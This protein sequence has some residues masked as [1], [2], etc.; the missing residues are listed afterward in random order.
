[1]QAVNDFTTDPGK[2]LGLHYVDVPLSPATTEKSKTLTNLSGGTTIA[3]YLQGPGGAVLTN[4]SEPALPLARYDVSFP[5]LVL[6][7]VG[8]REGTF[9]TPEPTGITPLTGAATTEQQAVHGPF[10]PSVFF[11][12]RLWSVNYFG[13]L[14]GLGGTT[15]NVTP[16]QYK[17][18]A[19]GSATDTLRRYSQFV[20]RLY[21][22]GETGP[23]GPNTPALAAPPAIAEID[24]SVE[25]AAVKFRVR[26]VGDPSAGIQQ[27]WVSYT[28]V[29]AG[30]WESLD[31]TQDGTDSTLWTGTLTLPSGVQAS[32]VRY[33]AQAVNGVGLTSLDDN[34]GAYYAPAGAGQAEP[35][36]ATLKLVSPPATGVYRSSVN[37]TAELTDT[38]TGAPLSGKVV[39]LAV[40]T[41]TRTA[42]TDSNGRASA[43]V[44]LTDLPGDYRLTVAFGGD[45]G[46]TGASASQDGVAITR[47][48][49]SLTID[50]KNLSA[51]LTA[52]GAPLPE[53]TVLLVLTRADGSVAARIAR[54]TDRE[55]RVALGT[56]GLG[57]DYTLTAYFGGTISLPTGPITLGDPT[58]YTTATAHAAVRITFSVSATGT[59]GGIVPPTLS[60]VLGTPASFGTFAPGVDRNYDASTSVDVVSSAGDA[61]LSVADP[62]STTTGRLVN[63]AFA[64]TEPLLVR[65]NAGAF[66]SLS[67]PVTLLTY[68]GP[69]SHDMVSV[70]FRQ[71]IGAAEPLRTGTYSKTLTFTLST[72]SP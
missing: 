38:A 15:L 17:A 50:A 24:D 1:V 16:A 9:Q 25:G 68:S 59:V 54:I 40:G 71:H 19:P 52:D 33:L 8:L 69:I 55:G 22:S 51:T 21:Y 65:A 41:S 12:L 2:T 13:A 14:T 58:P 49:T 32:D 53:Q 44:P 48:P 11:P 66:T 7:G 35:V 63:G 43:S 64:L 61:A 72:T 26:A 34:F 23:R 28:G 56:T 31:L 46:H 70:G 6:R 27:V 10:A 37:V 20:L 67:S 5:G 42:T 30:R 39:S 60:I 18:D 47:V 29:H 57:G 62:S 4:P 45:A 3:S 36:G